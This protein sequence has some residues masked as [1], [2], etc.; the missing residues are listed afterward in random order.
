MFI[1]SSVRE[2]KPQGVPMGLRVEE[3]EESE[4]QAVTA[5]IGVEG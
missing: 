2:S 5:W 4:G 1:R 3:S